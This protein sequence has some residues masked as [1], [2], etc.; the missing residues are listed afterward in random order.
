MSS[1][2]LA[3]DIGTSAIKVVAFDTAGNLLARRRDETPTDRFG[4]GLAEHDAEGLWHVCARLISEITADLPSYTVES[5]AVASVGEAGVPVDKA[6]RPVRPAIAWFDSR[7]DSEAAWWTREVGFDHVYR[8]SGQPIDR[9]YGVMRLM[10]LREHE[11]AAFAAT[12]RWL[13]LSDFLILRLSGVYATDFTIAS[14]TMLFDQRRLAWSAD[15]LERAGLDRTLWPHA[16]QSGTKVGT[17]TRDAAARSGLSQ[18]TP[19]VTGGHDRLCACFGSRGS[20]PVVVDSTGSAEAVVFPIR[21]YVERDAA[22]NGYAACYADVVPG[23]YV[24]SARVGYAGALIDWFRGF[25]AVGAQ[26]DHL[27]ID[28]EVGWPL[29][30]SGLLVYPSFGR[31]I[32][33]EWDPATTLGAI[34]G[35]TLGTRPAELAQAL[36]EGVQYSMRANLERL[37]ARTAGPIGAVRVE[38]SLT[39]SRTWMQLKADVTGHVI[40]AIHLDEA[41]ALGAALL[42]GVGAGVF[43]DHATAGQAVKRDLVPWQPDAERAAIYSRLY[44]T[45]FRRL[46]GMITELAPA[47][48]E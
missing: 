22:E 47:L 15:L 6:G 12:R 43:P 21:E 4:D 26:I 34:L 40:E 14:R 24:V 41:T 25:G 16:F 28:G 31:I 19:V 27:T 8:I 20:E 10:W 9:F 7:G 37:E 39:A 45:G 3:V 23:Q 30:P 13:A 36:I 44:E 11:P 48:G 5:V 1:A 38:G 42:G 17:V 46:P 32:A 29:R 18:G 2:L 33:P 35:L